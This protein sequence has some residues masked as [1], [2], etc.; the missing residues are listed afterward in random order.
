MPGYNLPLQ[1]GVVIQ[2]RLKCL[3]CQLIMKDP[4]QTR[5]TGLLYCRECFDEVLLYVIIM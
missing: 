3:H 1:D 4:V 5:E 2:D